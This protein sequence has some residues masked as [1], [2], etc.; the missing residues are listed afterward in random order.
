MTLEILLV[1]GSALILRTDDGSLMSC[2]KIVGMQLMIVYW[3]CIMKLPDSIRLYQINSYPQLMT[4]C[5][6]TVWVTVNI[7]ASSTQ[8]LQALAGISVEKYILPD[9]YSDLN[10]KWARILIWTLDT[11][12]NTGGKM[13]RW[14]CQ[15]FHNAL[16]VLALLF[17]K[18]S[19]YYSFQ[20]LLK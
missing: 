7:S 3:L 18:L 13:W 11:G 2:F 14:Q 4:G 10:L 17:L 12:K 5:Q 15:H 20:I 16:R 9:M 1:S 6:C 8:Y 19:F